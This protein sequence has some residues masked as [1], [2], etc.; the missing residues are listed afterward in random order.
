MSAALWKFLVFNVTT[1]QTGGFEF[2]DRAA[3]IFGAAKSRVGIDNCRNLHRLCDV[4]GQ[5][6]HFR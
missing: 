3:N 4:A 1:G 6:R 2:T 5:L